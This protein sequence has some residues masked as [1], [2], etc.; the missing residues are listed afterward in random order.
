MVVF[1]LKGFL[2][3]CCHTCSFLGLQRLALVSVEEAKG[4]ILGLAILCLGALP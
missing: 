2:S 1:F 3:R 4:C